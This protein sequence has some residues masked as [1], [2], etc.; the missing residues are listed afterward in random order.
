MERLT[1]RQRGQN[2][3]NLLQSTCPFS[4]VWQKLVLFGEMEDDMVRDMVV[5]KKNNSS[6]SHLNVFAGSCLKPGEGSHLG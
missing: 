5:E 3:A 4:E 1:F 2:K 6:P